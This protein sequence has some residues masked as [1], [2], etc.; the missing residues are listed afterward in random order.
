MR[1]SWTDPDDVR[2]DA[3]R[4]PRAITGWRSF[5]PLRRMLVHAN[6]GISHAHIMAA[7][8]LREQ[9]D[10]AT[11]GYSANR[12]LIYIAHYHLPRAGM[13]PAALAQVRAMRAVLRVIKLYTHTEL[14][15]L[16]AIVLRNQSIRAWIATLPIKVDPA[17]VKRCLLYVLDELADHFEAEVAEDLARG[18]RLTP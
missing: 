3:K 10:L 7:D 14:L 12:P 9:V 6:S 11:L 5:D 4:A 15:V 2:P 8:R 1:A 16:E 18:R 17:T 13:G